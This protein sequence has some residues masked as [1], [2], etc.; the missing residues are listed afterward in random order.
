MTGADRW[1]AATQPAEP[2]RRR[3]P[4]RASVPGTGP[5]GADGA[6]PRIVG[7][8]AEPSDAVVPGAGRPAATDARG[9]W[10]LD[11]RPPHWG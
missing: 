4:R 5:A 7:L 1:P 11:Q 8:N 9:R 10:I 6:E 2:R 3:G